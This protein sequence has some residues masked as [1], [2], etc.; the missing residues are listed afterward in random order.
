MSTPQ[1]TPTAPGTGLAITAIILGLVVP[2]VGL[3]LGI[4]A[5]VKRHYT[6]GSVAII[7]SVLAWIVWT[8]ALMG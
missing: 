8:I 6:L 5:L 7:V 2:L 3:I 4:I 1:Q